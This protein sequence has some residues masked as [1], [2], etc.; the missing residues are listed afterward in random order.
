MHQLG[1]SCSSVG[2]SMA[3]KHATSTVTGWI[4]AVNS[5]LSTPYEGRKLCIEARWILE[6][7]R[8]ADALVN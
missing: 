6:E 5:L 2:T 8:V 1:T 3:A 4:E 7:R